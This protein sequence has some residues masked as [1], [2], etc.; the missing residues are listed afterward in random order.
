MNRTLGEN[1]VLVSPTRSFHDDVA[2][3][4][5]DAGG[6]AFACSRHRAAELMAN[7]LVEFT[8][9]VRKPG[10]KMAPPVLNKMAPDHLSKSS[11][12]GTGQP[13]S[14]SDQAPASPKKT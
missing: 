2:N 5:R 8:E 13:S 9:G 1:E 7:N 12:D 4:F 6:G 10:A 14:A 3:E 11:D